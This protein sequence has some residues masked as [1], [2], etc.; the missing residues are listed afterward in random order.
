MRAAT[1][2]DPELKNW[3]SVFDPHIPGWDNPGTFHSS[4]LWFVFESLASCWRPFN[5]KHYDLARHICNYISN[6][7]KTGD[8]N[9]SDAD[10]TPMAKWKPY[11]QCKGQMRYNEEGSH[12][13]G[14]ES[15]TPVIRF[16]TD[17]YLSRH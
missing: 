13:L 10:G 4:D 14:D 1:K 15:V 8:P 7:I 2:A 16:L 9:G 6:F 3:S 12:Q 5:G 17:F 11:T